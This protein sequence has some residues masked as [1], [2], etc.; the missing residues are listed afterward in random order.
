MKLPSR[1]SLSAP[2]AA[3]CPAVAVPGRRILPR[4]I[5]PT[6]RR[7]IPR[8]KSDQA[9]LAKLDSRFRFSFKDSHRDSTARALAGDRSKGREPSS[10]LKSYHECLI[11]ETLREVSNPTELWD[12][13]ELL[14]AKRL[15]TKNSP[16]ASVGPRNPYKKPWE[17]LGRRPKGTALR[18]EDPRG[19][20]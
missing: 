8:T 15:S 9:T 6:A 17:A 18:A 11:P 20:D 2:W 1:L 10:I 14:T 5:L 16:L 19:D 12:R 7:C 13:R 4:R 3:W